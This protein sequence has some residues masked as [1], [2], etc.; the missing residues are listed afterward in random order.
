MK[1]IHLFISLTLEKAHYYKQQKCK[2]NAV[3]TCNSTVFAGCVW[4][5]WGRI[6]WV[7]CWIFWANHWSIEGSIGEF[8]DVGAAIQLHYNDLIQIKNKSIKAYLGNSCW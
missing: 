8:D 4:I 2:N 1:K 5:L 7:G 3:A 6:W